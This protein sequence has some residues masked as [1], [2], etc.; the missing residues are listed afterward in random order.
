[1]EPN[2][3]NKKEFPVSMFFTAAKA[4]VRQAADAIAMMS[5]S[6]MRIDVI[7]AGVSPTARLSEFAGNPE[8]LVVGVYIRVSG[9]VP[10][11][12]LL[13]IPYDGALRLVDMLQGQPDNTTKSLDEMAESVI[14]EAGNIVTGAYLKALSDFFGWTLWPSPPSIAVDMAAAVV[15]SVLMNTGHFEDETINIVTKF[16]G[17]KQSMKGFFLYIPEAEISAEKA[18]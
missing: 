5:S 3:Q 15:D 10:G 17:R 8:D 12:A 18:A 14:Q 2:A 4:G 1:M 11:H 6:E 9:E 16:T 13:V 7:S